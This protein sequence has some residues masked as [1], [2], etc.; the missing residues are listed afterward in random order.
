MAGLEFLTATG[1]TCDGDRQEFIMLSDVLGLSSLVDL[2]NAAGGA[3]ESTVLGPFH[4]PGAPMRAMGERIGRPEDG[5]PCLAGAA[6]DVW[7]S[8]ANGLFDIQ[9]PGQPPFNLRGAS[10]PGLTAGMSSVQPGRPVTPCPPTG[11]ARQEPQARYRSISALELIEQCGV[12]G[13]SPAAINP[14]GPVSRMSAWCGR[15]LRRVSHHRALLDGSG[16]C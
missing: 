12:W 3:T 2:N 13:R 9:D 16:D 11:Q 14:C 7:Q 6:L 4:V 15:A 10:P 1:R 8:S 5:E